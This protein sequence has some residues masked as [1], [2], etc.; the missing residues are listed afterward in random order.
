MKGKITKDKDGHDTFAPN[1]A[2]IASARVI[3]ERGQIKFED[4]PHTPPPVM[5]RISSL[6]AKYST[7]TRVEVRYTVNPTTDDIVIARVTRIDPATTYMVSIVSAIGLPET[8]TKAQIEEFKSNVFDRIQSRIEDKDAREKVMTFANNSGVFVD[9]TSPIAFLDGLS[10]DDAV[11]TAGQLSHVFEGLCTWGYQVGDIAGAPVAAPSSE[12]EWVGSFRVDDNIRPIFHL[13]KSAIENGHV[14]VSG[15]I[16]PSGYGKTRFGYALAE[17]LG[18]EVCDVACGSITDVREWFGTMH[19]RGGNT[20]FI[21]SKLGSMMTRGGVVVILDE[22]NRVESWM[23][24][25]LYSILDDRHEAT[26][27]EVEFKVGPNV[28]IIM[29]MNL[30]AKYT[31][32]FVL[33]EAISNRVDTWVQVGPPA[34]PEAESSIVEKLF[35][36]KLSRQVIDSIVG[37]IRA[38]RAGCE[39]NDIDIDLSTRTINGIAKLMTL[40]MSLNQAIHFKIVARLTDESH[41]FVVDQLKGRGIKV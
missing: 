12:L 41:R 3:G 4:G 9:M 39:N 21:T 34:L 17:F 37:V 11:T 2:L 27:G 6:A 19:A 14:L 33:D 30:G 1:R 24:N 40:G 13:A 35:G 16:G 5:Q 8:P 10:Y 36:E 38:L 25:A 29:T 31:G 26:V 15:L 20:S 18:L 28:V 7:G 23:L 32:T 22:I